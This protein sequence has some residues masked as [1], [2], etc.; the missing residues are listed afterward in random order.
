MFYCS[1]I[2]GGSRKRIER[3]QIRIVSLHY[4]FGGA[5]VVHALYYFRSDQRT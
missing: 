5:A 2:N 4:S 3:S 1:G